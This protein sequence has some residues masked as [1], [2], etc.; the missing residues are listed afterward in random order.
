MTARKMAVKLLGLAFCSVYVLHV[1]T[2][3]KGDS[4]KIIKQ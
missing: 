4:G 3:H 2:W 1:L